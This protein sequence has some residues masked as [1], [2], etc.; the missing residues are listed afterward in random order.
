M[1]RDDPVAWLDGGNRT[2]HGCLLP[3]R[4]GVKTDATLSLHRHQALVQHPD[5]QHSAIHRQAGVGPELRD[6][7]RVRPAV[8]SQDRQQAGRVAIVGVAV[9]LDKLGRHVAHAGANLA[10]EHRWLRGLLGLGLFGACG[11]GLSRIAQVGQK[12]VWF[13]KARLDFSDE[14]GGVVSVHHAVVDGD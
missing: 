4:L 6:S 3:P 9:D 11:H 13:L 2:D 1:R 14:P 10:R 8:R 12:G 7:R 5:A